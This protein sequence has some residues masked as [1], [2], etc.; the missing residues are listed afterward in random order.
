MAVR[1]ID[2]KYKPMKRLFAT[3][4]LTLATWVIQ[5]ATASEL[6]DS[7]TLVCSRP[8]NLPLEFRKGYVMMYHRE[9][10]GRLY[11]FDA[12]GRTVWQHQLTNAGFRAVQFTRRQT[13][14]CLIGTKEY[15]AGYGNAI[16]ELSMKGDTLLYLKKGQ[17]D[18]TQVIHH[19]IYEDRQNHIVTLCREQRIYDLRSK[20]GLARDTVNGDGIL[21]LDRQGKKIWK[22]T[23][24]DVADPMQDDKINDKKK[25]WVHANCVSQDNDGNF[26]ISFYNIGQIWKID[27]HTGKLLWRLGKNGD[28]KMPIMSVFDEAHAVHFDQ[29]GWLTLFDNGSRTAVSRA[30]CLKLDE[31]ERTAELM[32]STRLLP[33]F[34]T[35]RMGS[36]YLVGDTCLLLCSSRKKTAILTNFKG[37]ILWQFSASQMIPY[38]AEFIPSEKITALPKTKETGGK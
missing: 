5:K 36:A 24:F 18:F 25:D 10:P 6:S 2:P 12:G 32:I 33:K 1:K 9:I 14:L 38:R 20:G 19:E 13:F 15:E 26:L 27:A 23:V 11:L 37:D 30:I 21:I 31:K 3:I 29:R 16:I 7:F 8:A 35:D 4:M 28:F 17:N 22:W 34:Y